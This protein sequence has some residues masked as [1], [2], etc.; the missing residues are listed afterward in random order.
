MLWLRIALTILFSF[1]LIMILI[2]Q[3]YATKQP[4]EKGFLTIT[5]I[6]GLAA[7]LAIVGAWIL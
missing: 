7:I 4:Y 1:E 3:G 6:A 2:T 5:L